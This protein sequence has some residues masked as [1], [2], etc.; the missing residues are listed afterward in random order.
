MSTKFTTVQ[1]FKVQYS[2]KSIGWNINRKYYAEDHQNQ[3][4]NMK[5]MGS[6]S[7]TYIIKIFS[8]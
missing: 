7:I 2:I 8:L 3:Y 4:R 1:I 5:D 6:N